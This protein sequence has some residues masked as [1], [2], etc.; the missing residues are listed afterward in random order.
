[1]SGRCRSVGFGKG[2]PK[3]HV[4]TGS[5]DDR[6]RPGLKYKCNKE[7]LSFQYISN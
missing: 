7:Q 6:G 1:M 5:D 4:S 3:G 2:R